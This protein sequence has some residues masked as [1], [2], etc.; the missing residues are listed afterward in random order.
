MQKLQRSVASIQQG[1]LPPAAAGG[2]P[3]GAWASPAAA[4]PLRAS[5]GRVSPSRGRCRAW[6]AERAAEEPAP[7][8]GQRRG[9]GRLQLLLQAQQ[10]GWVLLRVCVVACALGWES[11]DLCS[12]PA[13]A[14][15]QL[16]DRR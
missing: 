1:A 8:E 12:V 10:Q 2:T 13:S 9:E 15:K 4:I 5:G 7:C 3:A 16:R 14:T 11:G 6:E